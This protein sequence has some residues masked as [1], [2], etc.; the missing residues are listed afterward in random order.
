MR[1]E[2]VAGTKTSVF[3]GCFSEDYKMLYSKDP[4]RL[5]GYGTTGI[6]DTMLANKL[7]W[8]FD[9]TGNSVTLDTACSSSLIAF[10]L[11]CQNLLSGESDMVRISGEF[12]IFRRCPNVLNLER[13]S[14]L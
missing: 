12:K 9:F 11:G 3:T 5:T 7:S 4:E 10:D 1:I 8:F 2:D 14:G 13:D 6:F